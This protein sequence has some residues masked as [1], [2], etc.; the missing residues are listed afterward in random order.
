M[1]VI[2]QTLTHTPLLR[3]YFLADRHI[4]QFGDDPS[5]CLVCE[6]S[7]LFQEVEISH[8]S[9]KDDNN[10]SLYQMSLLI[11][12]FDLTSSIPEKVHLT[13]HISCSIWFGHTRDTWQDMN[14]KML[15][16]SLLPH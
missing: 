8:D 14:N 1:N 12:Y 10:P 3:D 13:F 7:R 5:M 6:M 2:V 9:L 11:F 4:C 15:M 16:S